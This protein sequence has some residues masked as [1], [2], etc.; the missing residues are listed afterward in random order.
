MTTFTYFYKC[1]ACFRTCYL[2]T[3]DKNLPLNCMYDSDASWYLDGSNDP[4]C[5]V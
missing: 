3:D 1:K 5:E 2:E 4:S